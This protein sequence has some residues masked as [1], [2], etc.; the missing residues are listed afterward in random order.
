MPMRKP[1]VDEKEIDADGMV[2]EDEAE[3]EIVA[4]VS[5]LPTMTQK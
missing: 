1:D 4:A 2:E 5:L 3:I